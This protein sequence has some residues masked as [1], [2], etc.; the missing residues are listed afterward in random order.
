L[1]GSLNSQFTDFNTRLVLAYVYCK[2]EVL[3]CPKYSNEEKAIKD[4]INNTIV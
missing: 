1:K 3:N 2:P 4:A